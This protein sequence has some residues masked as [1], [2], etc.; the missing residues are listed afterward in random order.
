M[1]YSLLHGDPWAALRFN[2]LGV[3]A[4][5]MFVRAYVAMHT[6]VS[7]LTQFGVVARVTL[8]LQPEN[9]VAGQVRVNVLA[10]W[11]VSSKSAAP[12]VG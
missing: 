7:L 9:S 2:A 4:V 12:K 6:E 3:V 5:V 11:T 1:L 8:Y 10:S